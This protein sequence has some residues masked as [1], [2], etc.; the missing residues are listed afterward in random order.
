MKAKPSHIS[1]IFFWAISL[2]ITP[3]V[4]TLIPEENIGI[5]LNNGWEE[6]SG[7]TDYLLADLDLLY[8]PNGT[9]FS[10]VNETPFLNF[11]SYSLGVIGEIVTDV[12][13]PPP[14]HST[15]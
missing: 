15:F 6:E 2:L 12:V 13:L 3:L 14:E 7:E 11:S 8:Y 9:H 5:T 4:W 1:I 10:F